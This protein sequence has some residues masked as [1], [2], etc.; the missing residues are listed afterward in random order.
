MQ[1][2][3]IRRLQAVDL[4]VEGHSGPA[5]TAMPLN[6]TAIR[7][8]K[9]IDKPVKLTDGAGLY[10][11]LNA[12][13]SRWWRFDYRFA[14]KRKTLSMGMYR[15]TGL[16]DAREKRDAA[17]QAAGHWRRP[18]TTAQGRSRRKGALIQRATCQPSTPATAG[19][20]TAQPARS[21]GRPAARRWC[22]AG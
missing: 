9:P 1:Y 4:T 6:D 20:A 7:N 13:G 5:A 14:G 15:D 8:A 3:A 18:G 17:M 19:P 12:N 11:L 16:K 10:P 22:R 21:A 2:G